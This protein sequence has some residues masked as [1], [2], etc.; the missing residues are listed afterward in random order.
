MRF[1]QI[2][3]LIIFRC[4]QVISFGKAQLQLTPNG[5]IGKCLHSKLQRSLCIL[6]LIFRCFDIKY[7]QV[8]DERSGPDHIY[9]PS[10]NRNNIFELLLFLSQLVNQH[11]IRRGALLA[12]GHFCSTN[13]DFLIDSKLRSMYHDVL[14]SNECGVNDKIS[15]LRNINMCLSSATVSDMSL[16]ISRLYLHEVLH[17]FFN[18][19]ENVRSTSTEVLQ[20]ILR[21]GSAEL[22]PEIVPFLICLSTDEYERNANRANHLLQFIGKEYLIDGFN[23]RLSVK[24]QTNLQNRGVSKIKIAR[25]FRMKDANGEPTALNSFLYTLFTPCEKDRRSLIDS[26]IIQFDAECSTIEEMIYLADNLAY[27]PYVLRDEPLYVLNKISRWI[28]QTLQAPLEGDNHEP[29]DRKS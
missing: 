10:I 2:S 14:T 20:L 18:V 15:I 1:L 17:G 7:A 22:I 23:M 11:Q 3:I 4:I 25:G 27:F 24:F 26:I 13:L 6:G 8:D 5:S 29:T 12:L 9:P 16:Q 28:D 21:H 19:N